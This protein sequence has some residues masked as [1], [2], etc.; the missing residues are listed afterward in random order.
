M[1]TRF[2]VVSSLQDTRYQSTNAKNSLE[3][4]VHVVHRTCR[5]D[6]DQPTGKETGS[7][8]RSPSRNMRAIKLSERSIPGARNDDHVLKNVR[9]KIKMSRPRRASHGIAIA[10]YVVGDYISVSKIQRVRTISA[11][12]I[13]R[14]HACTN[15]IP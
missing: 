3:L 2:A 15:K 12:E 10:A 9:P 4:S 13:A 11:V 8:S 14:E 5:R 7:E 1:F 6:R